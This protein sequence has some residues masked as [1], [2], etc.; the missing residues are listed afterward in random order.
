MGVT[1]F[2]VAIVIRDAD[3][4]TDHSILRAVI[5]FLFLLAVLLVLIAKIP[6]LLP[7]AFGALKINGGRFGESR[8]NGGSTSRKKD[9]GV[10]SFHVKPE[11]VLG[12]IM[13]KYNSL[14]KEMQVTMCIKHIELWKQLMIDAEIPFRIAVDDDKKAAG[15]GG[16][17]LASARGPLASLSK[18]ASNRPILPLS[19]SASNSVLNANVSNPA[20][21]VE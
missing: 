11:E 3:I 13:S 15:P 2:Y 21:K 10:I 20:L 19:N 8:R 7:K 18:G 14:T 4:V 16:A 5:A 12:N 9:S 6:L 17:Y 1:A